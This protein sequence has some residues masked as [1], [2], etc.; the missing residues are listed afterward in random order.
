[1]HEEDTV[2]ID[3]TKLMGTAPTNVVRIN[4]PTKNSDVSGTAER[5]FDHISENMDTRSTSS[6]QSSAATLPIA[7]RWLARFD[8]HSP[9]FTRLLAA[10]II[11]L[12]SLLMV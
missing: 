6:A 7:I 3:M 11:V 9:W 2:E 10:L 12:L 5:R 8:A 1:M 4:F